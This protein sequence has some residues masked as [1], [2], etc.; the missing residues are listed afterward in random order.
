MTKLN[1]PV[2]DLRAED[3]ELLSDGRPQTARMI[4]RDSTPLPIYAVIVVQIA[5]ETEPALAKVKK[6]A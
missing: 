4:L 5:E 6:T 3:F 2:E 1:K